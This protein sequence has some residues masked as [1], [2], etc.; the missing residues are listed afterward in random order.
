MESYVDLYH[1]T[2]GSEQYETIAEGNI[3]KELQEAFGLPDLRAEGVDLAEAAR[4]YLLG[5]GLGGEEIAAVVEKLAAGRTLGGAP[6]A[7]GNKGHEEGG[8]DGADDDE[9]AGDH[10]IIATALPGKRAAVTAD[11]RF[12]EYGVDVLG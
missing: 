3:V 6:P 5:I 8:G 1:L 9:R 7:R 12:R 10:F 4:T 11:R 2:P